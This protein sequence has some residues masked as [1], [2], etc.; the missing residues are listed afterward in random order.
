MRLNSRVMGIRLGDSNKHDVDRK[1]S[2]GHE[3][4]FLPIGPTPFSTV[5]VFGSLCKEC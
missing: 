5:R 2:G 1:I 4:C 3:A